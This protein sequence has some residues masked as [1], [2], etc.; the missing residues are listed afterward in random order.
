MKTV[1]LYVFAIFLISCQKEIIQPQHVK[2]QPAEV[3]VPEPEETPEP[4]PEVSLDPPPGTISE[5]VYLRNLPNVFNSDI[6]YKLSKIY[7]SDIN[8]WNKTAS[9]VKDDVHTFGSYGDGEIVSTS[10]CPEHPFSTMEQNW[11][12]FGDAEGIKLTW[13]DQNYNPATYILVYAIAGKMFKASRVV[14]GETI[15][16][17]F[18]ATSEIK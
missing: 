18:K 15:Y 3:V 12:A 1:L 10:N 6:H 5:S 4:E 8:L 9:W 2:E 11:T 13:V 16:Y 17:E 14:D 7:T